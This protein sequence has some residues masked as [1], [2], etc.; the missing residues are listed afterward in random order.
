MNIPTDY[1]AGYENARAIAPDV[2]A[3]YIAHT[4]IGDPLGEAM[5]EDL[6][7]FSSEESRRL[8]E[9]AMND[10]DG[11]ALRSAPDSC[12]NSSETRKLP[13]NG[14]TIQH[15]RRV[16]ACFTGTRSWSWLHSSR[17]F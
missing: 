1:E 5:A 17:A 8:V 10:G 7:E 4:H 13:L 2:A 14:S 15:S 16:S 9:A 11:E 6:A 3:K 12:E